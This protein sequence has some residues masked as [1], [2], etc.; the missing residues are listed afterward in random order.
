MITID[1]RES[2]QSLYKNLRRTEDEFN[3]KYV[4]GHLNIHIATQNIIL[5]F[6]VGGWI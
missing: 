1:K 6:L 2:K 4:R 5:T 3:F